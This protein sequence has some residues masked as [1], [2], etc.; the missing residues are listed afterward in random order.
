L[1]KDAEEA[2]F[3]VEDSGQGIAPEFLPHVFE[4]FRQ[5]DAGAARK[6]GGLGIGLALVKQLADLHGGSV[7]AESDGLGSGARFIVC[8]PLHKLAIPDEVQKK[9]STGTLNKKLILV[10]DDSRET[11]EML[12][13]LLE[14]EGAHIETARSGQ[15]ALKLAEGRRFDLLISDI[16][17]PEMD[18]YELLRRLRTLRSMAHV[19]AL[20]L[21]GHGRLSDVDRARKEG[22]AEH[23]TKPLDLEKLLRTVRELTDDGSAVSDPEHMQI[24]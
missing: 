11:T 4:I 13:K 20:A 1:S 24:H 22:F 15:E 16:S 10:V 5:A 6:Q 2:K 3:I 23:F 19:P 7:R 14:M 8:I 21:T 18:G 17:M 9:I 12:S